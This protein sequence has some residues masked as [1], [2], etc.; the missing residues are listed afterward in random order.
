MVTQSP[1]LFKSAVTPPW[2]LR[3]IGRSL[4]FGQRMGSS[5][6]RFGST[7]GRRPAPFG[8]NGRGL[9]HILMWPCA[10]RSWTVTQCERMTP[11]SSKAG[12]SLWRI[13]LIVMNEQF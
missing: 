2:C 7:K 9:N 1:Q 3:D 12:K 13:I 5:M 6:S 10:M 4:Q 8:E 11:P